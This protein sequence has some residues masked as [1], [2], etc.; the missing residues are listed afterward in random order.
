MVRL[1]LADGDDLPRSASAS[2]GRDA[3]AVVGVGDPK[4]HPCT[5][6]PLLACY[7][8]GPPA[9]GVERAGCPAGSMV[10]QTSPDLLGCFGAG[11]QGVMGARDFSGVSRRARHGRS[12]AVTRGAPNRNALLCSLNG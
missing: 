9:N 5:L 10:P 2:R 7:P 12:P 4:D 3:K 11:T 6:G 8:L 1:A